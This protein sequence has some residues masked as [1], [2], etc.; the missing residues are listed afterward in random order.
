VGQDILFTLLI[1]A[2]PGA[3]L[4]SSTLSTWSLADKLAVCGVTTP[5]AIYSQ[6]QELVSLYLFS[7]SVPVKVCTP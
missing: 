6:G 7:P 5:L 1:H 2:G 3:H 4:A